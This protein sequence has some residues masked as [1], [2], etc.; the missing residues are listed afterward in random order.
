[1][2]RYLTIGG[3]CISPKKGYRN[4]AISLDRG[5]G[6][7]MFSGIHLFNR[8]VNATIYCPCSAIT[9]YYRNVPYCRLSR[10]APANKKIS[11]NAVNYLRVIC[12]EH[13]VTI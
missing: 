12:N 8:L 4:Q 5:I 7:D 9:D 3:I 11:I 1:M 6:A 2:D 13:N 10:Y